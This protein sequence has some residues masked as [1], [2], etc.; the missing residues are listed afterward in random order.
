MSFHVD[1]K[2]VLR[3]T[4]V[5]GRALHRMKTLVLPSHVLDRPVQ[6]FKPLAQVV[7]ISIHTFIIAKTSQFSN[8]Y[9]RMETDFAIMKVWGAMETVMS[10]AGLR[11]EMTFLNTGEFRYPKAGEW[12][13]N[14]RNEPQCAEED[15][16]MQRSPILERWLNSQT[17]PAV[18]GILLPLDVRVCLTACAQMSRFAHKHNLDS[19]GCCKG[20]AQMSEEVCKKYGLPYKLKG[21]L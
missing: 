18:A 14:Q 4:K 19:G 5:F 15:H 9:D 1:K 3:H 17:I 16:T 20:W 8:K 11:T 21:E 7:I 13:L 10:N 6:W 2:D 12:Y